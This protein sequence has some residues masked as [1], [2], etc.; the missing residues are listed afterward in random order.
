MSIRLFSFFIILLFVACKE[1]AQ[2]PV[3]EPNLESLKQVNPAP[4]WFKDAKFGIYFHWGV[5]STPAFGN[6]WYPRHMYKDSTRE[7]IHH[8]STYGTPEEWPYHFFIT[9]AKNK[10]DEFVQ[11]APKLKSEGGAFDPDEWAQLFAKSGARFAGPVAEHHDGFSLWDSKANPWNAKSHG[12]KMDLVGLLTD[13]IREKDMKVILSMHH[14]FNFTGFYDFV[15]EMSEPELKILYGQ[16]GKDKNESLWLNKHKEIIDQYQPDIIWQ[17][18]NLPALTQDTLLQFLAY[19]Y[20][21]A[22]K[23][24]KEVVTTYKDGLNHEV[25][26]L[27]YERGGPFE[28]KEYYWLTDDAMSQSSWCYTEG[29]AYYSAKAILHSLFDRISK[30]G[31]LLLNISPKADG[32][33]PQDQQDILLAIG[34]WLAHY[35]DAVFNTRAWIKFGEGPTEMGSGHAHEDGASFREPAEGK[36]EDIRFTK[37]KDNKILYAILMGWPEEGN[38]VNITSLNSEEFMLDE[39]S[40]DGY[41]LT[42]T[43]DKEVSFVQDETGLKVN[44]PEEKEE[45]MAYVLK[46]VF[47]EGIPDGVKH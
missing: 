31:N 35:G 8:L 36:P 14:A 34:D 10:Q 41:L 23:W 29:I 15:P 38:T 46:F 37:S 5:Y 13:A 22:E 18:F 16:Q 40:V 6:E 9:G 19:Y 43:D 39:G 2:S 7:N 12:P 32:S 21:A 17:D 4:E 33:I 24:G 20:N 45:E 26:V 25:A 28:L 42:R 30:N 27:D 1:E 3:Y 11:F 47:E 44:L